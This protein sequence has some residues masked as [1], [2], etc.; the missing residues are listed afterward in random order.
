MRDFGY[1]ERGRAIT[2]ARDEVFAAV[3]KVANR[4]DESDPRTIAWKEA[5][6]RFREACAKVYPEPLRQV[7]QGQRRASELDT[8]DIL[9]FLEADPMFFRSGYMK[10]KL[11]RE[12]KRRPLHPS[13]KVR[14]QE[15]IL[16]VVKKNDRRREFLAYC[17]V[18]AAVADE[19]FRQQLERLESRG[20]RDISLRAN[21][22]L[23][24]LD[25]RWQDLKWASRHPEV[26]GLRAARIPPRG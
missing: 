8:V 15:I 26:R 9:D 21:W 10:E 18:A 14:L 23:A 3:G 5:I 13:E 17:R 2:A 6:A 22:V 1:T 19:S 24:A 20:D 16:D 4:K 25:G 12:L 7:D 11:L